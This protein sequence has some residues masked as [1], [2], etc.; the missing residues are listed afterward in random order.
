MLYSVDATGVSQA[1]ERT[2]DELHG[3][4]NAP[5]FGLYDIQ[6]GRG[7]VG[8]SLIAVD[9]LAR[10]TGDVALRMLRGESPSSIKLTPLGH[11]RPIYDWR[12]LQRWGI[13]ESA[14]PAGSTVLFRQPG[15]WG[16]CRITSSPAR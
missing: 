3:A 5:I 6:L 10:M 4:A 1:E 12:E 15:V 16:L 8:G 11:G 9:E 14:L 7:V 13:A 2:L